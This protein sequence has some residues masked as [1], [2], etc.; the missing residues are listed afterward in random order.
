MDIDPGGD[1]FKA[2]L[3]KEPEA[4]EKAPTSLIVVSHQGFVFVEPVRYGDT[5]ACHGAMHSQG[6]A[7]EVGF[8]H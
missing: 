3:I 1:P 8:G 6:D 4:V 5:V 7:W 2:C